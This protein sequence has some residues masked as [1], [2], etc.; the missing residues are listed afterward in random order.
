MA[1]SN[2]DLEEYV[3][4]AS[5]SNEALSNEIVERERTQR[6]LATRTEELT[7]SN[8]DLEQFAYIAS[9]DL[10]EP[11]RNVSG[12]IGLLKET[13]NGRGGELTEEFMGYAVE[14]VERMQAL[15]HGLLSYSRVDSIDDTREAVDLNEIVDSVTKDLSEAINESG[16]SVTSDELPTVPGN[17]G[18]LRQLVQNLIANA[19]KFRGDEAPHVELSSAERSG[20]YSITIRDNGIG[21]APRYHDRVFQIF[22]RLNQRDEYAGTGIGLALCRRIVERHH[23]KIWFE[24]QP[25]VRTTFHVELPKQPNTGGG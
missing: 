7:R 19:I 5:K 23:G 20:L 6:E 15:I 4:I 3:G 24:S 18:L 11:L 13:F 8:R 17:S 21:M 25:D 16:G 1:R 9:H 14:G 2:R 12:S 22:Q 10:Q